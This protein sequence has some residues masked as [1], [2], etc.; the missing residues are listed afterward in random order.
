MVPERV[1]YDHDIFHNFS[2]NLSAQVDNSSLP[3]YSPIYL[4]AAVEY[5]PL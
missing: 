4:F 3:L 1:K 2:A 5:H